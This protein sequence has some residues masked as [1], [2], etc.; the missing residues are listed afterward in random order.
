M[1]GGIYH[2]N[3]NTVRPG[4]V[5]MPMWELLVD[6]LR[7]TNPL[8]SEL[9]LDQVFDVFVKKLVPFSKPITTEYRQC[10]GVFRL[11]LS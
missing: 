8:F 1:P 4:M 5:W 7:N 11:K 9:K 10:S 6:H 3:V 2:I